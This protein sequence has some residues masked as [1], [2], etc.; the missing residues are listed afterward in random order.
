MTAGEI[1]AEVLDELTKA[2]NKFPSFNSAH[3]GMAVIRE[4]YLHT[5]GR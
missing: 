3:E 5:A 4:E 2:N 1:L